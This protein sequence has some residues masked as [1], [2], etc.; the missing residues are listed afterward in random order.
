M[1]D[2]SG[3]KKRIATS[4]MCM[5]LIAASLLVLPFDFNDDE[6]DGATTIGTITVSG[7]KTQT[8]TDVNYLLDGNI[9]V[10]GTNSRLVFVNSEVQLSQDVGVDGSI[11]GGDDHIYNIEVRSGGTLVFKNSVLTTQTEQLHPYFNI[12]ISVSGSNSRIE[13]EDSLV[14]GPG[15]LLV[16]NNGHIEMDGTSFIELRDKDDL[17]YDI[18][19][20]GSS[21]DDLDYNNDAITL[22]LNSGG[23]GLIMDSEIRDTFSFDVS[24]RDGNLAGNITL[25]G[26]NTNLTVIN[27]FLD[28]DLQSNLST[29][30]H[31]VLKLS[32]GAVAHLVGVSINDSASSTS[33]AILVEDSSSKAV[34]YRWIAANVID[35]MDVQI[36]D[37]K[38]TLIRVEGSSERRLD[39]SYLPSVVLDYM[40][41]T[42]LT[43]NETD[44]MGWLFVP[45]ITDVFTRSSM[46]NSDV[47][48]DFK[49][50]VQAGSEVVT[51]KTSFSSY[52]NLPS[53]GDQ[54]DLFH[55]LMEG[56]TT[57][58]L[59]ISDLGGEVSFS[60][61]IVDPSKS[62]FFDAMDLDQPIVSKRVITGTG[63]L[64][65][66]TFYPSYY[67]F[68][69][70][71]KI[72]SGGHLVINDTTVDFLTDDGPAY[73]LIENGGKVELNN[74]TLRSK[75]VEDLYIYVLGTGSPMF[76][77]TEGSLD[78]G[79]MVGRD[80]A[81]F[82]IKGGSI[83]SSFN[84]HGS[85]VG[86][87]IEADTMDI[88][89]LYSVSN[90]LTLSGGYV[91]IGSLEWSD[92][93]FISTDASF[94]TELNI[95]GSAILTNV[96]YTG[97]ESQWL[98]VSGSGSLMKYYWANAL[99]TD[100]V[101]NPL[102]GSMISVARY[103]DGTE[104]DIMDVTMDEEGRATFSLLQETVGPSGR[105]FMGNYRLTASFRGYESNTYSRSVAGSDIDAKIVIPGGPNIVPGTI[106]VNGTMI[107]GNDVTLLAN[108]SNS[109]EFDSDGFEVIM[110]VNGQEIGSSYVEGLAS[111][112]MAWLEFPWTCS[113]GSME[114]GVMIDPE[115][116]LDETDENDNGFQQMNI[117]GLG[118]DYEITIPE[119]G[120][121]WV[122]GEKSTFDIRIR[123]I[124]EDDPSMSKFNVNI[125]WSDEFDSGIILDDKEI[126]YIP[127]GESVLLEVNWTPFK[128]GPMSIVA[129]IDADFDMSPSNSMAK[130]NIA[131]KTRP[132]LVITEG[133]FMIGAPIPVTVNTTP[134]VEIEIEN[135]GEMPAGPFHVAVYDL[136]IDMEESIVL[137]IPVEGLDAGGS[138][139]VTF[140]WFAGIPIGI[141]ELELVID[142]DDEVAEQ[143]ETNNNMTFEVMVDTPPDIVISENR[144]INPSIVTEG[145]NTTIWAEIQNIGNTMGTDVVVH[146]AIDSD[147]NLLRSYTLD[148]YPGQKENLTFF[149]DAD[150]IG[151]RRIFIVVDPF[152]RLIEEGTGENNNDAYMDFLV[153][154][155]PDLS[156]EE[157]DLRVL[158]EG[159]VFIDQTVTLY[160]TIR[161]SGQTDAENAFIRFYEGDPD[162][163]GKLIPYSETQPS[164]VIDSIPA[165]SSLQVEVP[166]TP[167]YG[168]WHE[169]FVVLDKSD[170]IE[171]DDET[172]NKMSWNVYVQTLPDLVVSNISLIQGSQDVDSAGVGNEVTFNV[173]VSNDGDTPA[174][175]FKVSFYNGDFVYDPLSEK[176]G[177]DLL[178]PGNYIQGGDHTYV[179][180]NWVVAYPKGI[181]TIYATVEILDGREQTNDNNQ[182]GIQVEIFDIE[183]V[184][185]LV[186]DEESIL[187]TSMFADM[188][189][190]DTGIGYLGTNISVMLNLSNM[191]GKVSPE[192]IVQFMVSNDTDSWVEY[193]SKIEFV[194]DNS[195]DV[196]IGYWI[197]D[198][199]G[200]NTLSIIIDPENQIRE[201]DEGNNIFE[202]TIEVQEAPDLLIDLIESE[203][204]G[205]NLDIGKFKMTEGKEYTLVYDITNLGNFTYRDVD[206]S[207]NGPA[208][209]STR[210]VT[211]NP[212]S[213]QRV[214]FTLTPDMV[215]DTDVSW[216]CKVNERGTFYESDS[217]NNEA[218]A[219]FMIEEEE[220]SPNYILVI[221][222][223]LIIIVLILAAIG[224][225]VYKRVQ[226]SEKAKCSNC[227]GLVD[228]D[229]DLC[230]HCGVE[231]SDELECECGE[232]IPKGASEC[233]A[234]GKPVGIVIEGVSSE[235][236]EGEEE[237][238]EDHEEEIEELEEES[239]DS[240]DIL[241]DME[242]DIED[243]GSDLPS[244]GGDTEEEE[245]AECFECGALIPVSAPICPHC[246]AVFE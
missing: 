14:E 105:T 135:L 183:D 239:T 95:D 143:D 235:E 58:D 213:T 110:D 71:L 21:S 145:K 132:D 210:T 29:G 139:I 6:V 63:S 136:T 123:N 169:I 217:G 234:C 24:S 149:W 56:D 82:D 41:R 118:P 173:T 126:G 61:Y 100:A 191:G 85:S 101:D 96:S 172:N 178:Y 35:G 102:P 156:M 151:E 188:S 187:L 67:S 184:P 13:F 155:R 203:S 23:T 55:N 81:V 224:F 69:G 26:S 166:W 201:F 103:D 75:G 230:P 73:M 134:T 107:A 242:K 176:I 42:S 116:E 127:S 30:S 34:Y 57:S 16:S 122:F 50:M 53:Q 125:I 80:T 209:V 240:E 92:V 12:N 87:S 194:M 207:F 22:E 158:P 182:K 47:T 193:T 238:S 31:N 11:G 243:I 68:D 147:T 2:H 223:V 162:V 86:A 142:V 174:P 221:I 164:I 241:E 228:L 121:N 211:V 200:L 212:Y 196:V 175:S 246:G 19:G 38:V 36:E 89:S 88:G 51:R 106:M 70:H 15:S 140:P 202:T 208:T 43:W 229:A 59:I 117:I 60:K 227:G 62:T 152:D 10:S 170:L 1:K 46:P 113:E 25:D 98:T 4:I 199:V 37:H 159:K 236:K 167:K 138:T 9:E 109:G 218:P 153:L 189:P 114:F 244:V 180:Y 148:L 163:G 237:S 91:S 220:E 76:K 120:N 112:Q 78:I 84:L 124:G 119:P 216:K 5:L 160:A 157:N 214:T 44:E 65:D 154:S 93:S 198:S 161:N 32:N 39:N 205:W 215:Y 137:P 185:E 165:S 146:F 222:I 74:V 131:V 204:Q 115:N 231:F 190:S 141:H 186:V 192:T 3:F 18:D 48:P 77:M 20:D 108:V 177:S 94:D 52:P 179:E 97:N 245:V 171:E 144:G 104:T 28:I 226:E 181:R 99:V 66:G 219:L 225:Y 130:L 233:P 49:I 79:H 7:G 195:T 168:G 27:S 64:V 8:Y 129:Q 72:E 197:L 54:E 133:S 40:D 33:P 111:G 206:V 90:T 45:A 232:V 128:A 150:G 83:E 17:S